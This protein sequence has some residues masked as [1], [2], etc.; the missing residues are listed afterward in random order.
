MKKTV[1]FDWKRTLYDPEGQKLTHGALKVLSTLNRK[2]INL[3][4]IGKGNVQMQKEVERLRVKKY[5]STIIFQQGRKD[6]KIFKKH[7]SKISKQTLVVGDRVKEEITIGNT[8]GAKTIWFKKGKFS[9]EVPHTKNEQPT[10]I[11]K[12]LTDLLK[13]I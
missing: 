5:F 6:T 7:L 8:I 9:K 2:K 10:Y 4:L 3:V 1:I 12:K 13:I 11:I